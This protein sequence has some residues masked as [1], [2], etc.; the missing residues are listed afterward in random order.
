MRLI[1]LL[2]F[3]L[4]ACGLFENFR[5]QRNVRKIPIRI[6][7]NGTRGKSSVTRLIAGALREAGYRTIAKTT[8]SEARIILED[9]AETDV[10]RPFGPRITEQKALFRLGALR[11][12]EALVIE[13]MAV[14]AESQMVMRRHLVRPTIGVI[15]NVRVD[16]IEEMGP[17][18]EET[19]A[20]LSFSIPQKHTL[21]TTDTRFVGAAERVVIVE[22]SEITAEIS[23]R[24]SYPVFPENIAVALQVT[25]ELGI[26]TETALR[27][28]VAAKPDIGVLK[29]FRIESPLFK[30]VVVSSFAANDI[31]STRQAWDRISASLPSDFPVVL[32]FNSREDREYRVAEFLKLPG[33]IEKITLVAVTGEHS[34]KV[35]K[36]FFKQG[37]DISAFKSNITSEALLT[38][39][40][41]KIGGPFIVFG[42]G[43]IKGIGKSLV[44]YCAEYGSAFDQTKGEGCF[45]NQ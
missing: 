1:I 34:A 45:R 27:G 28:M 11:A 6:L 13:C 18:L 17:T 32:L 39:L 44:N 15:T 7:V 23:S 40:G 9:G 5:H 30:A 21:I 26:D 37:I 20:A 10:C 4:L 42:V 22:P 8:G 36:L 2:G 29:I 16:H 12:A 24:F 35:A 25:A 14:R 31:V 33:M 19:A 3:A 41:S 43:N 38:A